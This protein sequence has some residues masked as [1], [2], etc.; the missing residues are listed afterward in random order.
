MRRIRYGVAL[1][2]ACSALLLTG[3][4]GGARTMSTEAA[5]GG[6]PVADQAQSLAK[7]PRPQQSKAGLVSDVKLTQQQ[8]RQIIYTGDLV[9]RAKQVTAAA[10][11]AKQMVTSVGGYL[12]KEES[13]SANETEDTATLEFKIPPARYTEVLGRLGKELGKQLSM[14]QGTQDVTMQVADVES[15]LRSAQQSL[16][17]L[18]A[19]LK[20]SGTIS[21]VLQVEREISAREADLESLQAQQKQ[22]AT[23]VAMATLTLRLVGP[24]AVVEDPSD[25]PA[26]FFGGLKAGWSALV[27]FAKVAVTVL[28]TVLPWLAVSVPLIALVIFLARR[29]RSRRPRTPVPPQGPGHGGPVPPQGPQR[30]DPGPEAA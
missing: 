4:G 8:D 30:G 3:C 28:G 27:S 9:V 15:R 11:Q 7:Q 24:V 18:R 22:L 14:N 20:K 13:N 19:L 5:S 6:A 16:E 10:Q 21:Q 23:Q 12:S 17:S 2:A 26:G 29:G 25:E 1:T